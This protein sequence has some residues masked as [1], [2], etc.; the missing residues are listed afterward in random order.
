MVTTPD[1]QCQ[2]AGAAV[3]D[4]AADS[5]IWCRLNSWRLHYPPEE[6]FEAFRDSQRHRPQTVAH[7]KPPSWR[8]IGATITAAGMG[9]CRAGA[10]VYTRG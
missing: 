5:G 4:A 7:A 3:E 9:F 1:A 8:A 10:S 6:L 2:P